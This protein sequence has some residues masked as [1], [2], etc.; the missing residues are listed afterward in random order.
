MKTWVEDRMDKNSG[1]IRKRS[2]STESADQQHREPITSSSIN[3]SSNS[4]SR[5]SSDSKG[6]SSKYARR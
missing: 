5:S 1:A 4:N 2:R 3:R 6:S